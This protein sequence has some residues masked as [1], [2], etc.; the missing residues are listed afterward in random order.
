MDGVV[1]GAE[2]VAGEHRSMI[3][4]GAGKTDPERDQRMPERRETVICEEIR[5]RAQ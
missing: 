4:G 2:R 5:C 3:G 1:R